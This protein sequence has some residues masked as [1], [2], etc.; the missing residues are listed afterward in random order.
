MENIVI[1][2]GRHH[3][4][5]TK[6]IK[7][8]MGMEDHQSKAIKIICIN[9]KCIPIFVKNQ[10]SPQEGRNK[11]LEVIQK[12]IQKRLD[13]CRKKTKK[14]GLSDFILL[15]PFS[16]KTNKKRELI[17]EEFIVKP[18]QDLTQTVNSVYLRVDECPNIDQFVENNRI[19]AL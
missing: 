17:N 10:G 16:V 13:Y 12:D 7:S 9:G 18:I 1:L 14:L 4:G 3:S 19:M 8:F 6:T 2:L 11:T 15:L 5:K